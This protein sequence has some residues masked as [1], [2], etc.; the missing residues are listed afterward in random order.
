MVQD[1][2]A[3]RGVADPSVLSAMNTVPRHA[4]VPEQMKKSAYQDNPLPIG[5][6]QTISQPYIVGLMTEAAKIN[7]NSK[8]LEIGTGSGYAAAILAQIAKEVYTIERI[9]PLA[10][11]A[12]KIIQELRYKNIHVYTGDGTLGLPEHAPFDAI[13]VTAGAPVI[14]HSFLDQLKVGGRVI[15]PVGDALNQRLLRLTKT[16]KNNYTEEVIELVRFV[17]LIGEEGW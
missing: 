7:P 6:G 2:I 10:Q 17:P 15:I 9:A 16:P 3:R 14:P 13:V 8:V 1:Q 12:E 4:F 5:E 11:Q